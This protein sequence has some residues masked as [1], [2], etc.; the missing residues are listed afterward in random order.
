MAQAEESVTVEYKMEIQGQTT[1]C[2]LGWWQ[3]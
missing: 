3:D 1:D 2:Q